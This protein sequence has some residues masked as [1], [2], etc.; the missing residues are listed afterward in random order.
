MDE[1]RDV[2]VIGGGSGG[3]AAA[4]R[5]AQ[6]GGDVTI[7][8]EEHFGGN[9]MQ[10]A[11]IPLTFLMHISGLM[12]A[13]GDASSF[14][15][16]IGEHSLDM[17]EL[18]DRKDMIIDVLEMG[19]EEQLRDYGVEMVKGRGTLLARDVVSVVGREI[20]ARSI[21]I[22]TGSVAGQ[23][24][25]DG[26][27]LPGVLSTDEA[28]DLRQIPDRIA[29]VGDQPWEIEL[30][31]YFNAMGRDV[32]LISDGDQ[33]LP[34]ADREISQRLAKHLHDSGVE[35]KRRCIVE[36]I[37]RKSEGG[38]EVMLAEGK[39]KTV[40]NQVLASPRF[41]NS[42]GL[43]LREVGV[44][45]ERGAVLVNERMESN[46]SGIYAIGDVTS[47][48]MGSHKANAQGI[49]AA[50]NAM[51][52]ETRIDYETLPRCLHTQPQVAWVG[53]TSQEAEIRGLDVSV[54]KIP[55]AIN[56]YAMIHGETDGA[57]KV[58]ADRRYGKI[59]GVHVMAPG[60]IDLINTASVAMASEATVQELMHLIPAH[61]SVGEA[62]VDAAMDV[63]GRS[64]H[65]PK[66]CF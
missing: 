28:I 13:L 25:I 39:G 14:G 37:R 41:P 19:T 35:V 52:S 33:L 29:V 23:L 49:V 5:G 54:G 58:V 62:L 30:A 34:D 51:G 43:G 53:L 16:E 8:E 15:L 21:I 64:L 31:Q 40:V 3:F 9:C 32:V 55:M 4:V 56:P 12:D 1:A 26:G 27:G 45:T 60:A 6:L 47:G 2:V 36:A 48:P 38:L 66:R 61:P 7:V 10:Q 22:A 59:L 18:H 24:P 42:T 17:Q 57:V 20:R 46:V 11:C 63:E 50:E 65:L 44:A